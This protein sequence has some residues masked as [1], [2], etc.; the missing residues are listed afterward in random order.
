MEELRNPTKNLLGYLGS[1]PIHK[2]GN[3]TP[4]TQKK[5]G[6]GRNVTSLVNLPNGN[7]KGQE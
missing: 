5:G 4:P 6:R 3:S 7:Y 1:W 2:P